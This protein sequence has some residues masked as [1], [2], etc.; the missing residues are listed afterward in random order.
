M[1]KRLGFSLI[2]V[3]LVLAVLSAVGALAWFG[4]QGGRSKTS[5]VSNTEPAGAV[6][7]SHNGTTWQAS[8]K[9]PT[10]PNPVRFSQAPSDLSKATAVLYPGQTRGGNYKPHGGLRYPDGQNK[11]AVKAI[12]DGNVVEGARYIEAGE[13]QYMFTIVNDCGIAYRFDH[14]L[15]LSPKFQSLAVKLPAAQPNDSRTTKFNSPTSIKAGEV[16]ATAVGFTNNGNASYDLGVYDLRSTNQAAQNAA[17]RAKHQN[18]LSQAGYALCW[19]DMFS[20]NDSAIL[21]ALPGGD[22]TSGKQSDYCK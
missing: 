18:I 2:E 12:Y 22:M 16:V 1:H 5:Q 7:W 19:L 3:V 4:M 17:Y 9:P 8:G 10:C 13:T 20:A 14:L 15:S 11:V 21:A 6:S